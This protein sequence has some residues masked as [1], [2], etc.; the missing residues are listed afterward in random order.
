LEI[1]Y[2]KLALIWLNKLGMLGGGSEERFQRQD[3]VPINMKLKNCSLAL[4]SS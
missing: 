1:K 2:A 4:A 3:R